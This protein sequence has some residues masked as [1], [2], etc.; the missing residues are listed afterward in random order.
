MP[1]RNMLLQLGLLDR[2]LKVLEADLALDRL[3]RRIL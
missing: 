3:G 1:S 2:A